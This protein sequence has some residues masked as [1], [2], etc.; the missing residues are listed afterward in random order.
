[1]LISIKHE[2]VTEIF[3]FRDLIYEP[4]YTVHFPAERRELHIN[5]PYCPKC[6]ANL[7]FKEEGKNVLTCIICPFEIKSEILN[8]QELRDLAHR[9]YEAKERQ[10]IK[11]ISLDLP[12]TLVKAENENEDY[13]IEARLGQRQGKLQG[14]VYLGRKIKGAQKKT[15]YAQILLD[16][17]DEQMRFDKGNQPPMELLSK[18]TVDFKRSKVIQ[19]EK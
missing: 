18:I 17:E 14:V 10:G 13:W 16:T 15:D 12:P 3:V 7:N 11:V 1:M 5:G 4:Y 2:P 6:R 9:A 19:E 8:Y